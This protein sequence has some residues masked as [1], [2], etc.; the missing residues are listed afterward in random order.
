MKWT[1]TL[2]A[3]VVAFAAQIA[4][5]ADLKLADTPVQAQITL[6]RGQTTFTTQMVDLPIN[7]DLVLN[8]ARDISGLGVYTTTYTNARQGG[9]VVS[10]VVPQGQQRLTYGQTVGVRVDRRFVDSPGQGSVTIFV[11]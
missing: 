3:L 1:N 2:A 5:G 11:K 6:Q 4:N 7:H 10:V 8:A 9:Q